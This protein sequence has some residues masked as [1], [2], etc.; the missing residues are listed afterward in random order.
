MNILVTGSNGQL[1]TEIK[2]LSK[3]YK[4]WNFFFLDLPNLDITDLEGIDNLVKEKSITSIIN[5]AAYTAVDLAESNSETAE[6]VNVLGARNL[7]IVSEKYD[8]KVVH[9]STDFVFDGIHHLPYK[10]T[11]IP[12]PVSVYGVT[13]LKGEND[14]LEI[15][16]SS[17]ILRTS[18]LYSAHGNNFVKTMQ[19]LGND[20]DILNII[21]DQVGT[22][23]WAGDLAKTILY[24]LGE[25]EN[26]NKNN[27]TGVYHY[28]NEGGASWFDFAIEI[29]SLSN[30]DC[31][32][33]PIETK[34]YPTPAARPFYSVLNK[35]KIKKE[36]GIKIPHWKESL[37]ICIEELKNN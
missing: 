20:R 13:K 31:L 36:L 14:I 15:A 19:K 23:T 5:C 25:L 32:V 22:P 16:P 33:L 21:F 7:A 8:I 29:M 11:D 4:K 17:I 12:N 30:I 9:V 18:W 27:F 2:K 28:S 26:N 1:G 6:K 35:S 24:L 3:N 34:E 37:K 10:E